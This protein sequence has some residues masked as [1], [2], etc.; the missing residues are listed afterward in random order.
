[1]PVPIVRASRC[2]GRRIGVALGGLLA[3]AAC[4]DPPTDTTAGSDVRSPVPPASAPAA[5]P[6]LQPSLSPLVTAE[7]PAGTTGA[8]GALPGSGA[9]YLMCVPSAWNGSL[10]VYAHGFVNP[11]DPVAIQDDVVGGGQVS[12]IVTGLGFAFATTSY[13]DNGLIVFEA[14]QD[15]L[16]LVQTFQRLFGTP[17][18]R[19]IVAGVSE[20]GQIAVLTAERNPQLFDGAL[21]ACGAIGDFAAQINHFDDFRVLFDF[22]FPGVIPGSVIAV[23]DAVIQAWLLPLGAPGSLRTLVL[24]SLAANPVATVQL[25]AAA[26]IALPPT[27]ELIGATVIQLL[28]YNILES[29]DAELQLIGQPFDNIGRIYPPPVD[30]DA[31][32]RFEADQSALSQMKAKFDTDGR[33]SIPVVTIHNLFDPVVP[34]AQE[35]LYAA[36]VQEAGA[37]AF[38]TQIPGEQLASPGGHCV[39]TLAEVQGAVALL[40]SQVAAQGLAVR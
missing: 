27:P 1:M 35:A 26:G 25:F 10:V 32:P 28:N 8:S 6:D 30:N 14:E 29:G 38:L 13:R 9:L 24:A 33:L 17:P 2:R 20:G 3:L 23:P 15:L 4:A 18:G 19:T 37:A 39:F 12:Q 36:K 16:R 34:Y 31:V 22:F 7:C 21:A 5:L 40:M 11:F